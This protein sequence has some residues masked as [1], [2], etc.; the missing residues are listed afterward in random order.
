MEHHR[1]V[2]L[3]MHF[4]KIIN[5]IRNIVKERSIDCRLQQ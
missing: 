2:C 3:N 4:M 1:T 5:M